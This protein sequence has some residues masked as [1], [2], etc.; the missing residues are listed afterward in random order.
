MVRQDNSAYEELEPSQRAGFDEY[1]VVRTPA[2]AR[3]YREHVAPGLGLVDEAA[4]SGIFARWKVQVGS[5]PCSLPTL[6]AAGRRDSIAGYLDAINLLD[7]YPHA[8]L[9]VIEDAGH[10]LMHEQ[11]EL[12]ATLVADWLDRALI[13]DD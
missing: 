6:L 5:D 1:F 10:A 12:L 8:T 11:P 3:R 13:R 2:T 4:L 9:A 7:R